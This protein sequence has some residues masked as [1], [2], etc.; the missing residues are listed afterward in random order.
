MLREGGALPLHPAGA[1][2]PS[3]PTRGSR[4]WTRGFIPK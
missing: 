1:F 2:G 4:P 3:T